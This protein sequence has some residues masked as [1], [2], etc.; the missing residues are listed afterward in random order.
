MV[1]QYRNAPAWAL[2]LSPCTGSWFFRAPGPRSGTALR[3]A[4]NLPLYL[5]LG[6]AAIRVLGNQLPRAARS[7][8]VSP[9]AERLQVY[10]PGRVSILA[11]ILSNTVGASAGSALALVY[12][13]ATSAAAGNAK[14]SR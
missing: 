6:A 9:G 7:V 4:I 1:N 13:P 10:V 12:R 5:P 14:P 8:P 11:D 2:A 3:C